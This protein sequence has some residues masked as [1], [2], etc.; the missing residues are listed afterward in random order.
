M[1][2]SIRD[3]FAAAAESYGRG[4]PLLALERPETIAL[5]P[6][7]RGLAVLDLGAGPGYYAAWAAAR[8]ARRTVAL[9]LTLEMLATAPRP[10]VVGDAVRLPF[11]AEAFDL[12]VAALVLSFVADPASMARE[13]ARVL[14][15]GGCLLL[16]DL[17][18]VAS[19]RGWRRTFAGCSGPALVIEAPPPPAELV[20]SHLAAAGLSVEVER[21]PAIDERLRPAFVQAGRADFEELAGT[22]LLQII[23]ARKGGPHAG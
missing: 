1:R 5:L 8:G 3:V 9:D 19:E 2:T 17:H 20:R 15:P 6:D 21:E 12:V 16:S 23:R 11:P 22:P 18:A 13:V 14:R 10:A 4:N 7:P